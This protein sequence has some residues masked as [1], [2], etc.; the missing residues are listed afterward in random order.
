[1]VA[2]VAGMLVVAAMVESYLRQS[3]LSSLAR[4]AFAA[5]SAVFWILYFAHGRIRL[6]A[7]Q[8]AARSGDRLLETVPVSG[9]VPREN[10]RP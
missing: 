5:A 2:G 8:R 9:D 4:L 6:T 10:R 1:M 7:A 3:H